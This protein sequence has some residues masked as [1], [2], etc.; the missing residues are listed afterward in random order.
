MATIEQLVTRIETRLAMVAGLDVQIH[1]E[2]R[3]IEM[4]RHKY[5]TLFDEFWDND[6][7][8]F[9]STTVVGATGYVTEDLTTLIKRFSDIH[10]VYYDQDERPLPQVALG[11]NPARIRTRSVMPDNDPEHVFKIVGTG[12]SN[13]PVGIWYRT[14][15]DDAVWNDGFYD[16]QIN[17]DDE[18]L[19][20][21]VVAEFLVTDDSNQSAA[22]MYSGL[23]G[24]RL[25]QLRKNQW[26][27]PLNKRKLDRDAPLTQWE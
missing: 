25:S 11:I 2:D 16:T 18:V 27:L 14:K 12:I 9:L 23:F 22:Q 8:E 1:A 3:L 15:I 19:L 7:T 26:N 17:M 20:L 5:N 21:G 6:T 24:Q 13:V 4:L 10:S